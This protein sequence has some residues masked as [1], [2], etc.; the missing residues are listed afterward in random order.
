MN[1][2]QLSQGLMPTLEYERIHTYKSF[3]QFPELRK[4]VQA[5]EEIQF[6]SADPSSLLR[7][8]NLKITR[9]KLLTST[10][11]L[12]ELSK[13][14]LSE[15]SIVM[16]DFRRIL[17]ENRRKNTLKYRQL[18]TPLV[19]R[20]QEEIN[21]STNEFNDSSLNN[22]NNNHSSYTEQPRSSS[23][24]TSPHRHT[25][26]HLPPL[27]DPLTRANEALKKISINF[28]AG[29]TNSHL[30]GFEGAKLTK[31]EF[32]MLLKRCL[33]LHLHR[34]EFDALFQCMDVDG[35]NMIDGVEF[36]RYFFH[37]GNEFKAALRQESRERI[38]KHMLQLKAIEEQK[39]LERQQ[40][41]AKVLE[42]HLLPHK[43][44]NNSNHNSGTNSTTSDNHDHDHQNNNSNNNSYD[45][46]NLLENT[47]I[48][49]QNAIVKLKEMAWHYRAEDEVTHMIIHELRRYF[50][51]Y[52]FLMQLPKILQAQGLFT[53]QLTGPEIHAL[54]Q[55]YR[56]QP[57]QTLRGQRKG[58]GGGG[59]GGGNDYDGENRC[60]DGYAF[61]T[62]FIHYIADA[63]EEHEMKMDIFRKRRDKV[64]A[65]GQY[66]DFLPKSLG[67]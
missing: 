51:K 39:K 9:K 23:S 65:M 43:H 2:R 30:K 27:P 22:D 19:F 18:T 32:Y 53:I 66:I 48:H 7:K 28:D 16:D 62:D 15:A 12:S 44:N 34:E 10:H 58:G 56:R 38:Y 20:S 26:T 45:N 11:K 21:E 24:P 4:S 52:E 60:V 14:S 57:S 46:N 40:Y 3:R 55:K 59:G 17:V 47:Q 61:V 50:T 5:I 41:E 6:K 36:I 29:S 31:Q 49:L 42:S 37:L 67:R 64:K 63:K 35:S 13:S 54:I 8:S 25:T 1:T 33:N